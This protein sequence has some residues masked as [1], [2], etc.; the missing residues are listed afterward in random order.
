M[1][2]WEGGEVGGAMLKPCQKQRHPSTT[3]E[4]CPRLTATAAARAV[5]TLRLV[6]TGYCL[7]LAVLLMLIV[8]SQL[9]I[10]SDILTA[11]ATLVLCLLSSDS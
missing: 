6:S 10:A 8:Q 5:F 9:G 3:V 1:V 4:S 7:A 2:V 11:S